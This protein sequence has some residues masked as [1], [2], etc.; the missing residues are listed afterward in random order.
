MHRMGACE[1]ATKVFDSESFPTEQAEMII[2]LALRPVEFSRKPSLRPMVRRN[3]R[4]SRFIVGCRCWVTHVLRGNLRRLAAG[5][6]EYRRARKDTAD[7]PGAGPEAGGD[8]PAGRLSTECFAAALG[9]SGGCT[10]MS[11]R[12]G[13]PKE[14][15]KPSEPRRGESLSRTVRDMMPSGARQGDRRRR[16]C[17]GGG[18]KQSTIG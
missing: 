7:C 14:S 5:A 13:R 2:G 17:V 4:L 15:D 16:V 8:D 11:S 18:R 6:S 12:R 10:G 1:V 9:Q 3:G